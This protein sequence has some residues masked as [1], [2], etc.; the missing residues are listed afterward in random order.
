MITCRVI[1]LNYGDS[2]NFVKISLYYIFVGTP[3]TLICKLMYST[4]ICCLPHSPQHRALPT[5]L[6]HSN[7][8][9]NTLLYLNI[10]NAHYYCI[11]KNP[12]LP[13]YLLLL[14]LLRTRPPN[15]PVVFAHMRPARAPHAHCV[16]FLYNLALKLG[17]MVCRSKIKSIFQPRGWVT[18]TYL[19]RCSAR[20]PTHRT[21]G[22]LRHTLMLINT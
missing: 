8:V 19:N 18:I 15:T 5:L 13:K 14:N 6:T 4:Y 10:L 17:I 20:A 7:Y 2:R 16:Y 3:S 9:L 12:T 1:L 21:A 11:C 22:A